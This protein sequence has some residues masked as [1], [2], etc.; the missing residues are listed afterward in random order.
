MN[1]FVLIATLIVGILTGLILHQRV[2]Q[3]IPVLADGGIYRGQ[4]VDAVL[5]GEGEIHWP[6][7]AFYRGEFKDGRFWGRG[8]LKM[9]DGAEYFGQFKNGQFNG[10]GE[11]RYAN[12]A[13]YVGSFK[14]D[15][16]HG[17]GRYQLDDTVYSGDF[18]DG[19]LSGEGEY[20][21]SGELVYK[22]GFKNWLYQGAGQYFSDDESWKG[23]FAEGQLSGEGEH[24]NAR[25]DRY[26]GAFTNWRYQ[27]KGILYYANGNRFEGDFGR[28][29]PDG[30]GRIFLAEQAHGVNEY[31]GKWK[32]GRLIES[33]PPVFVD[34]YNAKLETALYTEA[35]RLEQQLAAV[36]DQTPGK[37]DVYFLG[38]AGDGTQRVFGRELNYI[39]KTI[40][41]RFHNQDKSVL[42]INDRTQIGEVV[43][44]TRT[45]IEKAVEVIANK[46]DKEEDVL[47]IYM[48]SHGS[49]DHHF[50]IK[51]KGVALPELGANA[52]AQI[53]QNSGIK[54]QMI[55][56]SACYSGGFIPA[57]E[58]DTRMVMTSAAADRTSFGCSDDSDFTY[59]GKAFFVESYM[60]QD[61][62]QTIF[63]NAKSWIE[64]RESEEG[65]THSLPQMVMGERM[66]HKLKE[67]AVSDPHGKQ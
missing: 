16:F 30:E 15:L 42:L 44:A 67:I 46:M 38:I 22:G 53:L 6:N 35:Q 23:Q 4:L 40:H 65:L 34:D 24:L 9:S 54:W 11:L 29:K 3:P 13:V 25:G 58:G 31:S 55:M 57:L 56:I 66:S 8:H 63:A 27:G 43:M 14:D 18:V 62:W 19:E 5:Q 32:R 64:A 10:Q 12:G 48:T 26:V 47:L 52:L 39:E 2:I 45:S 7:G 49:R 61:S 51:Q 50:V 17:Q 20:S 1:K 33:Q 37:T 28:G 36:A 60:P 59:F 21:V 41:S